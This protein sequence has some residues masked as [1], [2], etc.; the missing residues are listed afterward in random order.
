MKVLWHDVESERLAQAA[1]DQDTSKRNVPLR[2][3]LDHV[4]GELGVLFDPLRMGHL[5]I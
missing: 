3:I 1:K 4:H 2:I 5:N